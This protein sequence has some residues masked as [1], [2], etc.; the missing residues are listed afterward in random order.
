MSDETEETLKPIGIFSTEQGE[1]SNE[2]CFG[3]RGINRKEGKMSASE[4]T[5]NE[6]KK[7][8]H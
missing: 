7:N 8:Y 4:I 1:N 2:I 6:E 3:L 5:I